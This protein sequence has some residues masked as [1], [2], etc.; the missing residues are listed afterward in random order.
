[1]AR[2]TQ[3]AK[4]GLFVALT[5]A[6]AYGIYRFVS[7]EVTGG[8]GY[9]VHAYIH[10]ATGLAARSRVTIAG[11]PVGTLDSIKLENGA[12]R[13]DVKVKNEIALYDN[14]TLGKKSASLLGES[15][16]VL[17]PGTPDR[18]KLHDGDEIHIITDETTPADLMAEVKSIA[19]DVKEVSKQLAAS[20]GT[21]QGGENMRAILQNVADATD[22]LNKTIRE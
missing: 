1:M 15:I 14:A 19:D 12:A 5:G 20:I 4:V 17:T 3:A 13:L 21:Q 10:D 18:V 22:A 8:N 7:P 9:T 11:I 6:A 2:G 16:I